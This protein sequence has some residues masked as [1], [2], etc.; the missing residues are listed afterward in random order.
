MVSASSNALSLPGFWDD[1]SR[2][3]IDFCEPNYTQSFYIAEVLNSVSSLA[4]AY[5]GVVGI[6]RT[7]LRIHATECKFERNC[8]YYLYSCALLIGLG[9]TCLHATLTAVGQAADEIPMLLSNVPF[10]ALMMEHKSEP[11]ALKY[12]WLPN[13]IWFAWVFSVGWYLYFQENYF[14]FLAY[15][16]G[17]VV[18]LIGWIAKLCFAK[19][20]D[21]WEEKKRKEYLVPYFFYAMSAYVVLGFGSWIFDMLMCETI[22]ASRYKM[23]QVIMHPVWHVGAAMG[24]HLAVCLVAMLRCIAMKKEFAVRPLWGLPFVEVEVDVDVKRK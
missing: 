10:L 24:T 15:Y 8:F 2:A 14:M 19:R 9:S 21:K 6:Y 3:S 16:V 23:F 4:I 11:N 18:T 13:F 12:P 1:F 7:S 22:L 20:S 5:L 17:A